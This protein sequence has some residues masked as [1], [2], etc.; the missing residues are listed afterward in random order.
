LETADETIPEDPSWRAL[1]VSFFKYLSAGSHEDPT[2]FPI[3]PNP[4]RLMP[5][6]LARVVPDA[7][8]L[9][10]SGKVADRSGRQPDHETEPWMKPI[11]AE[12]LVYRI[13]E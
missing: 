5:G 13:A 1:T 11:S 8:Q 4:V 3:T 12:K 6:G 10:G 9:I 2:R 7:F